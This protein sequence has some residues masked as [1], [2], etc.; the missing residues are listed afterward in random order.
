GAFADC[1]RS[2]NLGVALRALLAGEQALQALEDRFPAGLLEF[3]PQLAQ[4]ILQEHQG[5]APV[6]ESIRRHLVGRLVTE[7]ALGVA[8]IEGMNGA[9]ATALLREGAVALVGQ[10]MLT[11]R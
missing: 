10:E 8:G 2:G 1:E 5:P 7:A 11:S 3:A 9:A 6:V 4:C